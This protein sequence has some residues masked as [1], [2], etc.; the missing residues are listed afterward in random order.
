MPRL[1]LADVELDYATHGPQQGDPLLL[2]MGLTMQRTAWPDSLLDALAGH[3]FRV[4][5][6]DNRD[7]GLSSRHDDARVPGLPALLAARL[8]GREPALPYRLADLAD[9]AA[10]L[11]AALGIARA[12]VAGISMG[13]M[14]AQH[15]AA[16][17]PQR[18]ATLSLLATS[19]GRLGLPPPRLPVLRIMARRPRQRVSEDAAVDYVDALF[20]AIGSPGWPGDRGERRARAL[21]AVRRAPTGR[22]AERQLAA[23]LLDR[24]LHLLAQLRCP[25]LVLHGRDDA[26]V[27]LAH[28]RDLARRIPGARLEIVDGWG[29]DLPDPLMPWLAA[30]LAAHA[31]Q[32]HGGTQSSAARTP[33]GR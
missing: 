27:P 4:I 32:G 30:R 5:T 28:G 21:A 16:R 20:S 12:H 17:H 19:S 29:H 1:R 18:I 31:R 3:G 7:I 24:R 23:I 14:I 13:G 33:A 6:V 22:S 10:G 26:M 15:L 2:I 25:T 9:D 11:L 8:F